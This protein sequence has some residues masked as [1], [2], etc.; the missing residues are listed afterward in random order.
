MLTVQD[1]D[2]VPLTAEEVQALNFVDK[3][4][5]VDNEAYDDASL[6]QSDLVERQMHASTE[7]LYTG[8]KAHGRSTVVQGRADAASVVAILGAKQ[9]QKSRVDGANI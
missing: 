2:T 5:W 7:R 6:F 9:R 8:N 1:D 4:S 3:V